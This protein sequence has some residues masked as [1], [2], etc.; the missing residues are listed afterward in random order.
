MRPFTYEQA[1]E[2]GSAVASV[3]GRPD[4][5]YVAGGTN[6]VDHLKLGVATPGHLVDVSGLPL[7]AV[8]PLDDGRLR[9]GAGVRNSDLAAHPVVRRDYPVLAQALLA[10]ASGQIRNVAT[11]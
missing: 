5:M 2:P 8:E 4:A 10:G 3:A 7:D 1:T 11:T 9:I 6:L